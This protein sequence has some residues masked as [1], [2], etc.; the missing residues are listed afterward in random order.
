MARESPLLGVGMAQFTDHQP[1]TAHSSMMLVAGRDRACP[2][3]LFWTALMYAAF[4]T[5]LAILRREPGARGAAWPGSGHGAAGLP[6]RLLRLGAVPVADRPLRPVGPAR[7]WSGALYAAT[8]RHDARLQVKFGLLD[9]AAVAAI[10]VVFVVATH[11]YTRSQ[12]F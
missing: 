7:A 5:T 11:I 4:K 3:L 1:Q 8:R 12:G 2:G 10:D 9:L 6:D